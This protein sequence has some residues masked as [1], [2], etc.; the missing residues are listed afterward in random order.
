MFGNK[1]GLNVVHQAL[2]LTQVLQVSGSVDP[3]DSPTP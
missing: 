1:H 3:I 2:Q